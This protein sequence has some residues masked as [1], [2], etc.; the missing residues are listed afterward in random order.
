MELSQASGYFN[1]VPLEGWDGTSWIPDVVLGDFL[2]YDRFLGPRTFGHLQRMFHVAGDGADILAY[3]IVRT[4]DG[5]IYIV[6]SHN[7]D[8]VHS[9]TYATS[10]LFQEAG[11]MVE[12]IDLVTTPAPSGLGGSVTP[13]TLATYHCH[14]ERYNSENSREF[15]TVKYG[16]F[17]FTLPK[18]A[19]SVVTVDHELLINGVGFEVKEVHPSLDFT[20]VRALER[21]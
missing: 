11:Y 8:L 2:T 20:E 10:I 7:H 19:L 3:E 18:A 6:G 13:T 1:N 15:D 21:G 16:T 17:V 5:K 12:V 4:P 14:Y 9:D